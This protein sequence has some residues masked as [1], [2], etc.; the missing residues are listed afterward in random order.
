M[1][2]MFICF[3]KICPENAAVLPLVPAINIFRRSHL[4]T[5]LKERIL[6]YEYENKM[7]RNHDQADDGHHN[8]LT[9]HYLRLRKWVHSHQL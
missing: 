7:G 3:V 5:G 8:S 9:G 4:Y 2:K 1:L 6:D